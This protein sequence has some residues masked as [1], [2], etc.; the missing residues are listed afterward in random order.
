VLNV[1]SPNGQLNAVV[2]NWKDNGEDKQFLEVFFTILKLKSFKICIDFKFM[3]R[4]G[5]METEFKT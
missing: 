3:S 5:T 4:F 1:K 2:L